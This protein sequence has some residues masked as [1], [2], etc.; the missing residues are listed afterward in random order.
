MKKS[1]LLAAE[2]QLGAALVLPQARRVLETQLR[3]LARGAAIL[4]SLFC[5]LHFGMERLPGIAP[6]H[7]PWQRDI[8]A[9]KSQPRN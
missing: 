9:L 2:L 3:K 5:L 1:G 4:N 8:L 6:G 7:S